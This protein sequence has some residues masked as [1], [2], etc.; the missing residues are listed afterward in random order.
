V[1]GLVFLL[2]LTIPPIYQVHFFNPHFYPSGK[3]I[4]SSG[5]HLS[6]SPTG[7]YGDIKHGASRG[8]AD[9]SQILG[10]K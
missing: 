1:P 7:Q 2:L 9:F 10:K 6:I 3:P 5:P 8:A 4:C